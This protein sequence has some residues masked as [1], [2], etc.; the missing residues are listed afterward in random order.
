MAARSLL[1]HL[2]HPAGAARGWCGALLALALLLRL[3]V[4]QGWMPGEDGRLVL[5]PQAGPVA[6][7]PM[8][9]GHG[10]TP[11]PPAADHPCAFAALGL[12]A[13]PPPAVAATLLAPA[14]TPPP[15]PPA[16]RASPNRGLAAPPPPATGPPAFA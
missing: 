15:P 8:H 1:S 4:P 13:A 11:A 5:C 3:L 6:M 14:Q 16:H 9:H 7:A 2:R 10:K 12:A